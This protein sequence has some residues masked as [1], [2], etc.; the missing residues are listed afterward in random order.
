MR[1]VIRSSTQFY[2]DDDLNLRNKKAANMAD[3]VVATDGVNLGQ[4][5]AAIGT[6]HEAVA[7]LRQT[8]EAQMETLKRENEELRRRFDEQD[9]H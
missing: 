7:E 5:N 3:G 6:L 4:L 1:T 2:V 9:Q 8:I